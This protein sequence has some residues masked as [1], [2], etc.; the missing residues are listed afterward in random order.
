MK[1][2]L[3][4]LKEIEQR[5]GGLML[6]CE[7]GDEDGEESMQGMGR[8]SSDDSWVNQSAS[9]SCFHSESIQALPSSS[10][11]APDSAPK[12]ELLMYLFFF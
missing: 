12:E 9:S 6:E 3:D 8:D 5:G 1:V 11:P 7:N 4:A 10:A 2:C